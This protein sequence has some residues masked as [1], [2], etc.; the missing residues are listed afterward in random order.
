MSGPIGDAAALAPIAVHGDLGPGVVTFPCGAASER[1]IVTAVL[2]TPAGAVIVTAQTPFHPEDLW[3]PDQPTDIGTASIGDEVYAVPDTVIVCRDV[4]GR[5]Q[6]VSDRSE[7]ADRSAT[8]LF[9]GLWLGVQ[10]PDSARLV[11]AE[12]ELAV[13][14]AI[15]AGLSIAHSRS[16]LFALALNRALAPY[17]SKDVSNDSLGAPDFDKLAITCSRLAVDHSLE[18]YRLGKSL[19]RKG[20]DVAAALDEISN[21][22]GQTVVTTNAWTAQDIPIRVDCSRG[23]TLGDLR[24]WQ[25]SLPEGDVAIPCGGTHVEST[26]D[27]G[28]VRVDYD[29]NHASQQLQLIVRAG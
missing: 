27:I 1:S 21:V 18:T 23:A 5:P 24:S 8:V 13:D 20:F 22:L 25:C 26:A 3:W 11:G 12:V 19:R 7:V 17:W 10:L 28:L 6:I 2:D 9:V 29:W 16:H 4:T 14:P 15:R